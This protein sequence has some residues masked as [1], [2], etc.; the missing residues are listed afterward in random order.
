[1]ERERVFVKMNEAG[2]AAMVNLGGCTVGKCPGHKP[3]GEPVSGPVAYQ[4]AGSEPTSLPA[5]QP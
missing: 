4:H 5:P 2:D 1:M 3:G